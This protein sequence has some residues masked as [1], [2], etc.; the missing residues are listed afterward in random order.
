[1]SGPAQSL[2]LATPCY[3]GMAHAAYMHSLLAFKAA[4]TTRRPG[5]RIDLGGGDALISRARASMMTKF[6]ASAASH[7]LF[8]DADIGFRTQDVFRLLDAGRLVVGGRY[9]HKP[10]GADAGADG[11]PWEADLLPGQ[12][13]DAEGF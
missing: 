2:Y 9:A 13:P 7:L 4:C 1:M 10:D 12:E 11:E 6:L 3:G 5:L 8:V